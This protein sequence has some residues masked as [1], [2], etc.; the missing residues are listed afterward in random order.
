MVDGF[1]SKSGVSDTN[2]LGKSRLA[3]RL[4]WTLGSFF[5]GASLLLFLWI[6]WLLRQESID[7]LQDLAISNAAFVSRLRLPPSPQLADQLSDVLGVEVFFVEVGTDRVR[8]EFPELDRAARLL[9]SRPEKSAAGREGSWDLAFATLP[10]DRGRRL[11]LARPGSAFRNAIGPPA[12]FPALALAAGCAALAF[13]LGRDIVRP[14]RS[15]RAWSPNLAS[16]DPASIPPPPSAV[17]QRDD[18]IGDLAR[19]LAS[20]A[21]RMVE[22]RAM[23]RRSERL[24]TL[25]RI[26]T[27]LAHEV[28]NP[29]A[30]IRL[31]TD[32]LLVKAGEGEPG[33]CDAGEE[34]ESLRMIRDEVDRISSLVGQWLFVARP[35]PGRRVEVSLTNWIEETVAAQERAAAHGLVRLEFDAGASAIDC[36]VSVDRERIDQVLRNVVT[37]AIQAMPRGGRIRI[38]C[39]GNAGTGIVCIEDEGPGFSEEALLR[40]GEPFFSEREGGMGIGLTLSKEVVTAHG[41]SIRAWNRETGGAVVEIRLPISEAG[42][43]EP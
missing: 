1:R 28:R 7:A 22:E 25:G 37:N 24:A 8:P 33:E 41:G 31:H 5:V 19:A 23:R 32:L 38:E 17:T 27:S 35:S 2:W 42:E 39:E 30:A 43:D 14:L 20:S 18:E 21:G 10:S 34:V 9:L 16:D 12:V 13:G 6:S 26:A 36:R 40:F 29:A 4:A 11:L 3:R 15:I